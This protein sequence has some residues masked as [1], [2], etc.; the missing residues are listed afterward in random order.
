MSPTTK[1]AVGT[2]AVIAIAI[3]T[4]VVLYF[5]IGWANRPEVAKEIGLPLLAIAG[6]VVLLVFLSLVSIAFA[7]F[8]LDDKSQALALPEGSIRAVIALSLIVLFAILSIFLYS[9]LS[10]GQLKT[11]ADLTGGQRDDFLKVTPPAQIVMITTNT[12][13]TE[14]RFTVYLR[15]GSQASEDFAKQVLVLIGTLVTAVASFYFGSKTAAP[16]TQPDTSG[17]PPSLR[18]ISPSTMT[19]GSGPVAFTI[20]GDNLDLVKEIKVA[21][22]SNQIVASNV[23]SNASVAKGE[24]TLPA[25]TPTGAWEVIVADGRGRQAKLA[26]AF[27]IT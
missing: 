7:I 3:L 15:N 18:S 11:L 4:L 24:L 25:N 17:S 1:R 10:A 9:S 2:G 14:Q 13:G 26:A 23:T 22:G 5:L 27:T 19:R 20:T 6:I 21:Q 8:D 12:I 16:A